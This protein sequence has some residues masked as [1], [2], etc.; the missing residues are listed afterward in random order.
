[1]SVATVLVCHAVVLKVLGFSGWSAQG[2]GLPP[3]FVHVIVWCTRFGGRL[4]V[5]HLALCTFA[6]VSWCPMLSPRFVG[7]CTGS[8]GLSAGS[9][10]GPLKLSKRPAVLQLKVWGYHLVCGCH[11]VVARF[12]CVCVCIAVLKGFGCQVS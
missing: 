9:R 5:M 8:F 6:T 3:G 11:A 2:F 7:P 12:S 1:M 10:S 4:V